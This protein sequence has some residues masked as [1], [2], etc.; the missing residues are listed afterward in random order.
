MDNKEIRIEL[1]YSKLLSVISGRPT[2]IECYN[3]QMRGIIE[4]NLYDDNIKF[5]IVFPE[6]IKLI[7]GS[8]L[9]GMFEEIN[10]KIGI[11][12]ISTMF[13]FEDHTGDDLK[14]MLLN[15]LKRSAC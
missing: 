8:Y 13:S 5:L 9:L 3:E 4:A 11:E 14:A 6:S 15:E 2:G 10:N 7:S 1:K 12:G